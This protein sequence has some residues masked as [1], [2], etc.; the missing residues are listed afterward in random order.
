MRDL[1][2]T[3][4]KPSAPAFDTSAARQEVTALQGRLTDLYATLS[5][6][7]PDAP[8]FAQTSGEIEDTKHRL[9]ELQQAFVG[10]LVF[11]TSNAERGLEQLQDHLAALKQSLA[12]GTTFEGLFAGVSGPGGTARA[13]EETETKIRQLQRALQAVGRSGSQDIANIEGHIFSLGNLFPTIGIAAR[14]AFELISRG[15]G[16]AHDKIGNLT[17]AFGGVV[18]GA[19]KMRTVTGAFGLIGG[20]AAAAAGAVG[21]L[22]HALSGASEGTEKVRDLSQTTLFSVKTIQELERVA[23]GLGIPIA[24]V[25]QTVKALGRAFWDMSEGTQA[26]FDMLAKFQQRGIE[27]QF[28]QLEAMAKAGKSMRR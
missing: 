15:A 9:L 22:V 2:R 11:D 8:I 25:E 5:S 13:I 14:S 1:Q 3:L 24:D 26:S 17:K 7:R 27:P 19:A 20:A 12:E 4:D 21:G 23:T 10:G 18:E 16:A 28:R 6:A